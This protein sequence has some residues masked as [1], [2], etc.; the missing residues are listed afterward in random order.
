M[1]KIKVKAPHDLGIKYRGQAGTI[2]NNVDGPM[3]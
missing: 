3:A 1:A 2:R